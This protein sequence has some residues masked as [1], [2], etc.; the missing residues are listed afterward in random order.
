MPNGLSRWIVT[1]PRGA[2]YPAIARTV[3]GRLL[4]GGGGRA[5]QTSVMVLRVPKKSTP[6]TRRRPS[7][8]G[9][10]HLPAPWLLPARAQPGSGPV[11]PRRGRLHPPL[12]FHPQPAPS[13][14]LRSHRRRGFSVDASVRIEAADHAGRERLC[15]IAPAR[16]LP[17]TGC[18]NSIPSACS[19]KQQ[20]R[21]GRERPAAAD[22][23]NLRGDRE[24]QK[25]AERRRTHLP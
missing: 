9:S 17:W 4:H 19:T 3:V 15:V 10:A 7:R 25:V 24:G 6:R 23:G 1:N 5:R 21:S 13:L 22:A 16:R 18:A 2:R 12:R 11:A 20:S 14:P 8:R